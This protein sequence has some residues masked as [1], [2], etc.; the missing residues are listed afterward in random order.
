MLEIALPHNGWEPRLHQMPLWRYLHEGGKRAMAV[1]HRRAGKDEICLHHAAVS[2]A[3]R[4]GN[5]WHCL[6][7]YLQG[8]KAI[9]T[10]IN[11]HTGKRRIDEAFPLELRENTNDNEMFL[12]FKNG[13]TFQVIGS[14]NY[15]K[16]VGA[17]VAGCTYSE[18]ALANPS[19]WAYHRPMIEENNGWAIFITTPRGHNH[20]KSM[21]DHACRSPEWFCQLLNARQ[22]GMLS[23]EA[24]VDALNEYQALYGVDHGRA[25]F[26][27]EY[28]C[29]FNAAILG[30]FY[31][32]E[33]AQVRAEG[34][35]AEIEA[36]PD[37]YVHRA[38]DLGVSDDTSIWWFQA[39]GSQLFVLDFY[40]A[41]GVGLEHY[42]EVIDQRERQHGWK[43]GHDYVPHDAKVKEWGTGRTRVETMRGFGLKPLLVPLASI[44]DGINAARRSLP[45]SV[46]HPRCE[47]GISALEQ[48]R[49]EWDDEKKAFRASHVHDW[50]SHPADAFRYLA[51]SWKQAPRRVFAERPMPGV[52]IPPPAEP[53][54]GGIVL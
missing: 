29:S 38:W 6:P 14:D 20:A 46:F 41:S 48:Y 35:I 50:T 5:Y 31:S 54:R 27:Q 49:R 47:A 44:G 11:P 28:M 17:S 45:L 32:L 8:R 21:F 16:T 24:L 43:H 2:A 22:T 1:W 13:S 53:Q 30:A 18:W 26:E 10:A 25:H 12:R 37:T 9:W 23:E 33:M 15:D 4:V 40:S 34:R 36:L 7:E 42:A 52:R 39:V 3:T 51:M 19:A